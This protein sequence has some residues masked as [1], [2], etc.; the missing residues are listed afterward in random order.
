MSPDPDRR[1][2]KVDLT[3]DSRWEKFGPLGQEARIQAVEDDIFPGY[4][5]LGQLMEDVLGDLYDPSQKKRGPK[6]WVPG[7]RDKKRPYTNDDIVL[8]R[9]HLANAP[10]EEYERLIRDAVHFSVEEAVLPQRGDFEWAFD[11][12]KEFTVEK[13]SVDSALWDPL[14]DRPRWNSD[15]KILESLTMKMK[16]GKDYVI[17]FD[18][19]NALAVKALE[20]AVYAD[21]ENLS[22][23]EMEEGLGYEFKSVLDTVVGHFW[24]ILEHDVDGFDVSNRM[25]FKKWWKEV[26]GDEVAVGAAKEELDSFLKNTRELESR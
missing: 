15:G 18:A 26:M 12:A 7:S 11:Q 3:K 23:R 24:R 22:E 20:K 16:L 5:L 14:L 17:T 10:L 4:M 6:D 2:Y 8:I 25:D 21:P 19:S 13:E 1:P 9:E